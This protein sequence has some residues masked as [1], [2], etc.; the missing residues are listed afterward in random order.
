MLVS[1]TPAREGERLPGQWKF[2]DIRDPQTFV[3]AMTPPLF[4]VIEFGADG[5][6]QLENSLKRRTFRG[7][8]SLADGRIVWTFHPP[9][10]AQPIE[11]AVH[12]AFTRDGALVLRGALAKHSVEQQVEWIFHRTE[13]FLPASNVSGDWIISH[14]EDQA[15]ESR[16]LRNDGTIAA[17]RE[18]AEG[19]EHWGQYRLWRTDSGALMM[20]TLLWVQGSGAFAMF[21]QV[22]MKDETMMLTARVPSGLGAKEPQILRRAGPGSRD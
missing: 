15:G 6:I 16:S 9:D 3:E 11:H 14:P 20:T 8:Y 10:S 4:D 12:Y 21:E 18:G 13:R 5:S 7:Q 19:E 1:C 22:E 17:K 2:A